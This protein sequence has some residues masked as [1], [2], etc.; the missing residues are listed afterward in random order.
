MQGVPVR[1]RGVFCFHFTAARRRSS[2]ASVPVFCRD[3]WAGR[4]KVG[5]NTPSVC[6]CV[7]SHLPQ[8]DGQPSQALPRQLSR[9]ESQ[10]L[11]LVAKVL[12]IMGNFSAAPKGVPL[13]E[14]PNAVRLRGYFVR[15]K[16]PE[17]GCSPGRG[18]VLRRC[19]YS[20]TIK[21]IR[22]YLSCLVTVTPNLAG[23]L[24]P[25]LFKLV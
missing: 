23:F 3:L 1:K 19:A 20:L 21:R 8:G 16:A 22:V 13:G 12:G 6:H 5:W 15:K 7:R 14:L 17:G 9:R 11:R 24:T 10:G 18:A 2:M 4:K 25:A